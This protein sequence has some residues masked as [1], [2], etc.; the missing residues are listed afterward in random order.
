ML[1]ESWN[2]QSS[3]MNNLQNIKHGITNWKLMHFDEVR[4]KKRELVA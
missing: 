1:K 2:H 3:I 4:Q